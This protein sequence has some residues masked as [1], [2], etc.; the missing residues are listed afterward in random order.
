MADWSIRI[1][2]AGA[3]AAF[4]PQLQ[5]GGPTGL[6]VST[7]DVVSWN[8]ATA[9]AHQPW[10]ADS[11]YQPLSAAQVGQS[12]DPNYLS[13]LIPPDHSSRPSWIAT[14]SPVTDKTVYYVCKLHPNEH[15]VI[16]ITD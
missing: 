10:P 7:G 15:G 14:P 13:D 12:G 6:N 2:Q 3:Q 5:P 16:T 11:S 9:Q 1:Q 4:V 8:N